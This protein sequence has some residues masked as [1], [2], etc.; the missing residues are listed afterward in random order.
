MS[1]QEQKSH[2]MTSELNPKSPIPLYSQVKEAILDYIQ[3]NNL[4]PNNMLPSERELSELF[5]VN[6][7]T[8]R[9]AMDEMSR[10]G[11]IFR[12]AGKGSFISMPKLKQKL[13]VVTSFSD[14]I[15]QT[16]HTP[17]A[18]VLEISIRQ[19]GPKVCKEMEIEPD[20]TVIK[21]ARLRY[22]DY[23]PF[24]LATSYLKYDLVPGIEDL[25]ESN[26]FYGLLEEKYHLKLAK[27]VASLEVTLSE[28]PI[29]SYLDIKR[30]SPLFLMTGTVRD[31]SNLVIE[32]FEA[33]YRGDRFK[34]ITESN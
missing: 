24:S 3:E 17:G 12:Q 23:V 2:K 28:E 10:Q 25:V 4:Q 11:I 20:T 13:L 6:R 30:G 1:I 33:L 9:K 16:G 14:A 29:T 21:I 32:Y 26:S 5:G 31:P 7:L 27:T 19:G 8:V 22:V 34:F 15:R 18:R